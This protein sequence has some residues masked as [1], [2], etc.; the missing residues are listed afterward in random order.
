MHRRLGNIVFILGSCVPNYERKKN[1]YWKITINLC[2]EEREKN[3]DLSF[4]FVFQIK[5]EIP[6]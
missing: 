6:E 2:R 3:S 4:L 5:K 1:R